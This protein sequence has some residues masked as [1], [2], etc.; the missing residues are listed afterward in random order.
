MFASLESSNVFTAGAD[1]FGHRRLTHALRFTEL[2]ESHRESLGGHCN[3]SDHTVKNGMWCYSVSRTRA[4]E[5]FGVQIDPPLRPQH[6]GA[7]R[8]LSGQ[9]VAAHNFDVRLR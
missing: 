4:V 3:L 2:L 7:L 8:M 6:A 9:L 5:S 1:P